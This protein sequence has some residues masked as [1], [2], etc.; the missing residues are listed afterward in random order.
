[1]AHSYP[2][3]R[4]EPPRCVDL[5][6]K[7]ERERLS[8]S[9]I[10]AFFNVMERWGVR[11]EDARVLLGGMSNGRFYDIK[12]KPERTLDTDTLK[13]IS[14][15]VGIFKALNILYS[16]KLA[17]A[18]VRRAN[19]NRIFGGETP[20]AHMMKGGQS[21]MQTVRRLVDARRGGM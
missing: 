19:T 10:K 17:D 21:A 15:L 11:D 7:G 2:A 14:Y 16:E 1:M 13:R 20:L 6:A 8:P 5:S 18:W 9:A 4:Y 3:T 12:K